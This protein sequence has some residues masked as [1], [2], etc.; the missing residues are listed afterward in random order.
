MIAAPAPG[1]MAV[2]QSRWVVLLWVLGM[3]SL[4]LSVWASAALVPGPVTW[5]EA[6][7]ALLFGS[8]FL[9]VGAILVVRRPAAIGRAHLPADR[10]SR[11]RRRPTCGRSRS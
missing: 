2:S 7:W 10:A 3:G 6:V 4:G 5:Q 1:A 9:A 11:W 8:S